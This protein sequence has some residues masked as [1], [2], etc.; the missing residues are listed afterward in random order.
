MRILYIMSAVIALFSIAYRL[1]G[2][3]LRSEFKVDNERTTPARQVN[4]GVDYVPTRL[5][6]LLAQHFSS[7][8]AAGPIVGPI[9]AALWFGWLPALLWIVLGNIFI[10]A[11]HDFA[12]LMAS[13]RHKARSIAEVVKENMSQKAYFLFLL[14]IW[15]SLIYVIVAFTDLT[16][17]TFLS[18]TY[19]AGVAS[20]S[21]LYLLLSV[22]LGLAITRGRFSL[23]SATA[24]ALPL[25]LLIIWGG[26][27]IPLSL[28]GW[29]ASNPAKG[30]DV[31]ILTYCFF[32]SILPLWI[33]LQ[34][35]GYLGGYFLYASLLV[36]IAG[37]LFGGFKAEY[38]AFIGFQNPKGAPLF[39]ILFITVACGA[40][41]GFHGL[42]CS[43]TSSKQLEKE[44]DAQP[45]GYGGMLL[46]GMVAVIALAT[47][48]MIPLGDES[49][50]RGPTEI[51]A[52]GLARFANLLGVPMEV[53]IS[54]GL[55]A[56]ATFVYD[57]LDVATRLGRYIFQELTGW[58][59]RSGRIGAT[60]ATLALPLFFLMTTQEAAY[61]KF[62]PIFGASNQ[63]LAA[64]SLL[65]ISVWLVKS[66]RNPVYTLLP[67]VFV[68]IMTLW[69]L[70]LFIKPWFD[71]IA[72][73][74]FRPDL[75]GMV[76]L[77]LIGIAVLLL[78]E[79]YQIMI[80]QKVS[81]RPAASPL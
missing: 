1:Y 53:A 22:L 63:L 29:I 35:R 50:R 61:L 24:L 12:N 25:L 45:I 49:L 4:D 65:G 9:L 59:S 81:K 11:A 32:A 46:E 2:R 43:G 74:S 30:W 66:G 73:G 80:R 77:I 44:G 42:V 55:L 76:A 14:F 64:L 7:I 3:F 39:P 79:G 18:E 6:I 33:L 71:G 54:F 62:W 70:G 56:F 31:I 48:M 78:V 51:Y 13:V 60:F 37:L 67:M 20:S 8:A 21:F 36:G 52:G 72:S 26:Q 68:L 10:G 41:S 75:I 28:P 27:K 23:G 34:P 57:T 5:P 19:G 38:P 40:C 58:Q 47:V 17:S 16:A 15:L 69:A